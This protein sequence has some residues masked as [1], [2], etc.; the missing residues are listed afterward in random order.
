MELSIEASIYNNNLRRGKMPKKVSKQGKKVKD[1]KTN[2]K[3]IF[4]EIVEILVKD[5][6]IY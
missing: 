5:K 3:D 2:N 4:S 6:K 1:I